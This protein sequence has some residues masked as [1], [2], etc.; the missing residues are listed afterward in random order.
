MA[1]D[2]STLVFI[3]V[4]TRV[5]HAFGKPEEAVT[6][7]KLREVMLT[8]EFYISLHPELPASLRID[9]IGIELD[10]D[11]TLTYFNHI[12]NVTG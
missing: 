3:E 10:F 8:A 11:Q 9:V 6:Q 12:R 7:R 4:K 2:G 5:G 1:L